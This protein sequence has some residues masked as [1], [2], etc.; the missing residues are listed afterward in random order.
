M[1]A[2][3][4]SDEVERSRSQVETTKERHGDDFY[5]INGKKSRENATTMFNSDTATKAVNARW[6]KVRANNP[7]MKPLVEKKNFKSIIPKKEKK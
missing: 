2:R 4:T 3:K 6:D 5:S 1:R 7:D